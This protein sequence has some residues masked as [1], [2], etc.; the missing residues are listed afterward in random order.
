MAGEAHD[1]GRRGARNL[2]LI[3]VVRQP[4]MQKP[5]GF[6]KMR[7]VALIEGGKVLGQHILKVVLRSEDHCVEVSRI[8]H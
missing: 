6:Q 2:C 1:G 3:V 4:L 7:H 8:E 5:N